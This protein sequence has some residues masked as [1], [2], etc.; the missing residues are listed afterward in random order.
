MPQILGSNPLV[1]M[2]ERSTRLGDIFLVFF[3]LTL[4]LCP[5][6]LQYLSSSSVENPY[7]SVAMKFTKSIATMALLATQADAFFFFPLLLPLPLVIVKGPPPAPPGC[8]A[9]ASCPTPPACYKTQAELNKE[10]QSCQ[11]MGTF[12]YQCGCV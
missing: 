11:A 5:N 3:V 8:P 10:Q 4:G 6:T 9:C 2:W 7:G 1:Y 12:T